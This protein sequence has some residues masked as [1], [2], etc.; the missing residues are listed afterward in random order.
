METLLFAVAPAD[1]VSF[2]GA[3]AVML[4]AAVG[5]SLAPALRAARVD[6]TA[7]LRGE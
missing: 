7:A 6:P 1:T 3:I 4:V 2:A 5:A